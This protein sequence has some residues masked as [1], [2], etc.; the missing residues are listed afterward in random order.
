[1]ATPVNRTALQRSDFREWVAGV[2]ET[3]H[4]HPQS[5]RLILIAGGELQLTTP[6]RQRRLIPGQ[7]AWLP[8]GCPHSLTGVSEDPCRFWSVIAPNREPTIIYRDYPEG[9]QRLDANVVSLTPTAKLPATRQMDVEIH[10][11]APGKSVETPALKG[12][13]RLIYALSGSG[14]ARIGHLSG[15]VSPHTILH[16]PRSYPHVLRNVSPNAKFTVLVLT[17]PG[18]A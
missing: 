5:E 13:E 4:A 12:R 16:V 10:T 14:F 3:T 6:R 17:F 15:L 11:L 2:N 1:M 7:L 8:A 9:S 18:N